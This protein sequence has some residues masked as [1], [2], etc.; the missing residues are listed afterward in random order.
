MGTEKFRKFSRSIEQFEQFVRLE[1]KKNRGHCNSC[2]PSEKRQL[3]NVGICF[4]KILCPLQNEEI[5]RLR[6]LA[7]KTIV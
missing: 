4:I 3:K 7:L 2:I 5:E 1:L 6:P